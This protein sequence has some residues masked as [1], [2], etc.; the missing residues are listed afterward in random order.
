MIPARTRSLS[1]QF[2]LVTWNGNDGAIAERG[3]ALELD[4]R[5]RR[6]DPARRQVDPLGPELVVQRAADRHVIRA[7]GTGRRRRGRTDGSGSAA[8][9]PRPCSVTPGGRR[10]GHVAEAPVLGE[11]AQR[12]LEQVVT[13]RA[14]GEPQPVERH[15]VGERGQID[16]RVGHVEAR[17]RRRRLSQREHAVREVGPCRRRTPTAPASPRTGR[18]SRRA[19]RATAGTGSWLRPASSLRKVALQLP[20]AL[21]DVE[22]ALEVRLARRA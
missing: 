9:S 3:A 5:R 4:E 19:T 7:A 1:C 10:G 18:A 12:P 21:E 6:R 2:V 11:V 14:A 8:G 15:A 20:A 17:G 16:V 22:R 13:G